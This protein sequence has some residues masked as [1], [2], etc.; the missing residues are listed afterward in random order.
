M[1][2]TARN[3]RVKIT[4]NWF[5]G[6]AIAAVAV[7]GFAPITAYIGSNTSISATTLNGMVA[8]WLFLSVALHF[9]ARLTLGRIEE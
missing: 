1:N 3:E 9:A 6:A 8:G 7:G 5:N 4:A 2:K